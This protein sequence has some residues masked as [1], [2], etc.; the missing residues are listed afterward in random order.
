MVVSFQTRRTAMKQKDHM[1]SNG[2]DD[3]NKNGKNTFFLLK[4]KELF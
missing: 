3:K 1:T 4:Q 2:S